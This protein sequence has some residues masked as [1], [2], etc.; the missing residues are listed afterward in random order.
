MSRTAI[1]PAKRTDVSF[2][3]GPQP[4]P[5]NFESLPYAVCTDLSSACE[6][7]CPSTPELR[8]CLTCS[9]VA[10]GL[11]ILSCLHDNPPDGQ[12]STLCA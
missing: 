2:A 8:A 5:V 10:S 9:S 7:I 12:P 3:Y 4:P 6:K 11:T 1:C